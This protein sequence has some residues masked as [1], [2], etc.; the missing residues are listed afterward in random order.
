[1]RFTRKILV[2]A[3]VLVALFIA[4]NAIV[5]KVAENKIA[6][7]IQTSFHTSAKPKVSLR[8]FPIIFNILKGVIPGAR[9]EATSL[10]VV[11]LSIS[12]LTIDLAGI[13]AKLSDL[14]SG[15]AVSIDRGIATASVSD[16][17]ITSYVRSRNYPVTIHVRSSDVLVTGSVPRVGTATAEGVP[18]II[19]RLL[20]Y[21]P[22]SVTVNGQALSGAEGQYARQR[23]SFEVDIPQLPGGAKISTIQLTPGA[24]LLTAK[25]DK[26]KLA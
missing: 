14:A 15:K 17:Q 7:T 13:H 22:D 16:Q 23:L 20:I 24:V 1:M 3:I 12:S 5:Q 25:L 11:D 26:T 10:R 8:G 4:A 6:S 21:H 2:T 18:R 19:G 9:I